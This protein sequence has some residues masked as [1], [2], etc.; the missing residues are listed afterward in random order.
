MTQKKPIGVFIVDDHELIRR[1]LRQL[2]DGAPDLYVCGEA[3][4]AAQAMRQMQNCAPAVTIIDL[5]LP[6]GNGLDLIKRL[7]LRCPET[8]ILV[9]SMYDEELF[10]ER[11]LLA[12]AK[13]YINKQE[14][15]ARVLDAIRTIINGEVFLSAAV[16]ERLSNLPTA[17]GE[18]SGQ[19]S[20]DQLSDRELEVFD[21]IGQGRSTTEIAQA[22][23]LSVKTIETYRAHIKEKLNLESSSALTRYAIQWSLQGR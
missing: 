6:D 18:T 10:A 15:A 20:I 22:L 3:A 5:C 19:R 8:N 1:G 4:T 2:I 14:T 16:T 23:H 9:S 17:N 11:V 13:G 21:L 7:R 12:G